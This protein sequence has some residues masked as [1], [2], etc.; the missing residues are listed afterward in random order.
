MDFQQFCFKCCV[1]LSVL[2]VLFCLLNLWRSGTALL[3]TTLHIMLVLHNFKVIRPTAV[4][5]FFLQTV[6]NSVSLKVGIHLITRDKFSVTESVASLKNSSLLS[7]MKI[8]CRQ[9]QQTFW[10]FQLQEE[11]S[12]LVPRFFCAHPLRLS[13]VS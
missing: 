3:I 13:E 8:C 12:L 11:I 7:N 10:V 6:A 2:F 1:P 9:S 4:G 5:D